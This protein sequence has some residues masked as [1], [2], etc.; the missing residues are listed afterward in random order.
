MP[1]LNV[2]MSCPLLF[3]LVFIG[4]FHCRASS[5]AHYTLSNLLVPPPTHAMTSPGFNDV[6]RDNISLFITQYLGLPPLYSHPTLPLSVHYTLM[7]FY[8]PQKPPF[9]LCSRRSRRPILIAF[10]RTLILLLLCSSG[11]VEVNPGPA[12]P[13]S[14]PIPQALSFYDFCNRNSL[15]FMH[16]NIRSLLPKFVLFTAL[17]HSA[18]PDVLA[19]SE[20]WLRKTTKNS[21]ILIPNYN[22]FRQDRT[23]K[24]GGVA[25]YCKDSLQSS[26]LLSRSVPKQFELLLL[27]IH[28]SKN[29]SLTIAACYRPPSAP[30][31]ALDTICE[32]IA[33]HLSSELVL[34]GDLNWNMLNTPA[35]L[36]SKL[37][38]LNLTQ[39]INEPTRYLPKA[40][41]T[42]TLIDIILTNFPSKYTSAVFNQDLSDHCL[43]ACIRNGSAV[44]RPPLIT[45]KRSLKHFSEQAFLI[46]LAGVSWKDIDLIPSV[47]DA[48]IFFLNAFL[49]I[50]NK[51]APFKK[52]RTRNRYSPWFSPDL[53]ALNQHKNI[54]WR[55]ALASNSPR[56]M[57]L[58][59]EARNHYTQAVRKAKASFFKQK[60]ASCNTNSK[61]FWDTVK[62]MENKNTSSQLPTALKIGNTV[63]TDK[64]T[65]IEHFNKHFSTAGHA[66][67]LATPTP[68]NSTA[69]PTATRPSLP[70]FSFSQIHSADVLKELQNLDPYKSAGLDNLDP[71]FLKLSAEIVATP[72]T[73]LFNLSFV[74]SEIPKDWKAAAVIPLFKG[75]DTLDP[76]CYRPISIQPCLSKVFESQVNKQITDH[77]ESHHTFSAMQ[78]GFRAGH[79]CTSAT[80]KVLN[81]I[82]TAIDKK[83]YCAAVFIDLAKAFD[84]VNH[85]ILIGRLNSLGFSNDCLAWFTNYFS[86]R[87]QCVKSEGLLSGPLAVSMGVPQGSILGPTLF[88]VYINEVALAAGESLIHLYAD[89]TILYT[90]GP[91]LDTVLTTLQASF[92]ATQLS[93]RGLQLLLNTSKTKCMLFNRSLP[94][95]TRLSNITTLDGSDLEYVGNYKYLGVWLDCKLSF[96]THI[97]HLQSKVKSRIG[98]LFRNK[99]SFTHAAKHTLVKLTIL[100][101]LDF[102]DVIYKIASNTL[103]NKLDAVYHSAIRFVTKA[104][105][106]TRHCDLYALVGWPSLH[107]RRQTHW[108]HVIYKT[109][110]GKVPP[111]LSSLVTIASPTCS[112]RS[113]RYIS[114]VTPKTNSF[115]GR[116]SFQ[117]SA[118]NDWNEL[119]KSLKL[120]TLISLTSFKHQLSEQLTDYCTCT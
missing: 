26:V 21:D 60:F 110:L 84:S 5:P 52:F 10:S 109:L 83:H 95:P 58:F 28:L 73:S 82:L 90:S 118:A 29:K 38:A 53:T 96:Q 69:P 55:S 22:I 86:D 62:S 49:T 75:G 7:L 14:T 71:F 80:L 105:Y 64:S 100:P 56:D 57:Q 17:A 65:I 107:T 67:H 112:T 41:N 16:V 103:L 76:N 33:P 92:N 2:N 93:F 15:G 97:K 9:T 19:V 47:E 68:V 3:W 74:S 72:I 116:L 102:G 8:R 104:P 13:S 94:A 117:F 98:F 4:L 34:L 1:L 114:L 101:I 106:T 31:C 48:W 23:A 37:D 113:S 24:G 87:V 59:R 61:K 35:I 120:E 20:S 45:V 6:S 43:I 81:Y 66:F 85:H 30:S 88:S 11:D 54:L 111:Y 119:Q 79:G 46:D 18:N 39:I 63:T 70:H 40:L 50:L 25:I 44:K 78:S 42:G 27:K 89:D 108:L 115:F 77:F 51:H 12:V 99:A 32:L 91:S 36:Q